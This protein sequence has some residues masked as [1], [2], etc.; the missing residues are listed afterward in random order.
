MSEVSSLPDPCPHP[1]KGK[2]QSLSKKDTLLYAPLSNVGNVMVDK[3][4]VYVEVGKGNYTKRE[5]ILPADRE[6]RGVEGEEGGGGFE[7]GM[8]DPN[9]PAGM[10]KSLQ[11][12]KA[13]I[14]DK[15]KESKLRIFKSRKAVRA[16]S[17]SESDGESDGDGDGGGEFDDSNDDEREGTVGSGSYSDSDNSGTGNGWKANAASNATSSF[18]DRVSLSANL[19][20]LVYGDDEGGKKS[21]DSSSGSEGGEGD[22]NRDDDSDDDDFFKIKKPETARNEL[23]DEDSG[24]DDGEEDQDVRRERRYRMQDSSRGGGKG[25]KDVDDWTGE[26]GD[27]LIESLRNKFVT[28][29]WDDDGTGRGKNPQGGGGEGSDDEDSVYDDFED[30]ET[31]EKVVVGGNSGG[32]EEN[33]GIDEEEEKEEA[34]DD[35]DTTG[36]T[37]DEIRELNKRRKESN[38]AGFNK[39]Y[40]EDK[41]DA[42]MA[43][44]AGEDEENEY[45][46]VLKREKE[47]KML[48]NAT[49]FGDEGERSRVKHEGYR[50]GMYVRIKIEKVPVELLRNFD[51]AKPFVLGGLLPNECTMGLIRCRFKKHR[52]HKKILKC[53]D[54]LVFSVG[55]RRFQSCVLLSTEDQNDRHRYLKYTPEHM[56]CYATFYGPLVPPNTGL[57]AVKDIKNRL[58]GFR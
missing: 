45:L 1:S 29:N 11:D 40:D 8:Y 25:G 38:K 33:G 50:Q 28:G 9:S 44:D 6:R 14:G 21:A 42:A 20:D 2:E 26:G 17:D 7:E 3:D 15:M 55:W 47:E 24:E 43:V 4:A 46:E 12:V 37:D 39:S 18:L 34:L 35:V 58:K 56:H 30:F 36:M 32:G 5:N 16:G 54:P 10:L 23:L 19:Q 13:S 48:R 41:K 27:D 52:W 57:L 49:E 53:N 31:G 51:P 22:S